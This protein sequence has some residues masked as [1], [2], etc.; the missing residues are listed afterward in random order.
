MTRAHLEERRPGRGEPRC[1]RTLS[2]NARHGDKAI[3]DHQAFLVVM[4][5]QPPE[6]AQVRPAEAAREPTETGGIMNGC[7][8]PLG[9]VW[10]V[11]YLQQ[12]ITDTGTP[13]TSQLDLCPSSLSICHSAFSFFTFFFPFLS[14][15][16]QYCF[17]RCLFTFVLLI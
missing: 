15:I 10:S 6:E 13:V 7:L 8:K 17:P 4:G 2:T 3:L 16:S 14:F 11:H 9:L 1:Q 5:L 12:Q